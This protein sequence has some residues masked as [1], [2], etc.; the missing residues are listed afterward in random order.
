LV[1]SS[2]VIGNNT[3]PVVGQFATRYGSWRS[4]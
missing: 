3:K 1:L 4:R 2:E